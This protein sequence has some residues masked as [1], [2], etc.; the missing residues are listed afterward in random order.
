MALY[1]KRGKPL[2][3]PDMPMSKNNVYRILGGKLGAFY[4]DGR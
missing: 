1:V 4:H 2:E 3:L